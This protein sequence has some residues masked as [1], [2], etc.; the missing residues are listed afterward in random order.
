VNLGN[1]P[2]RTNMLNTISGTK[3][4]PIKL[5]QNDVKSLDWQAD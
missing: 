1:E 5:R 4:H 3:A 2:S